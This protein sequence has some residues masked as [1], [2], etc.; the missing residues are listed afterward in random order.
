MP[1]PY[2]TVLRLPEDVDVVALAE[3]QVQEWL[4][5]RKVDG[6]HRKGFIS[7]EFFTPGEHELGR[8]RRLLVARAD[9][10]EDGSRR[11]LLRFTEQNDA[12]TW[13]VDAVAL[14]YTESGAP[15]RTLIVEAVRVDDPEAPGQV[16]PPGLVQQLLAEQRVIDGRTVVT[17][18]PILVDIDGIDEAFGAITDP[19]R[20]VEVIVAASA[21]RQWEGALRDRVASLTAK[22]TGAASVY[23]IAWGAVNELNAR[24]GR[25]HQVEFG[26]IR[27]FVP[28]V[29][30][31]D[32]A[33]SHR[34]R[35][36]GPHTFARA[37]KGTRV[38]LGLQQAFAAQA[39]TRQLGSPLPSDVRRQRRLL[40]QAV[41]ELRQA[42][43]LETHT[44]LLT[45]TASK[46]S[47]E[48][49]AGAGRQD[50][51]T[52]DLEAWFRN[53]LEAVLDAPLRDITK[54][55][56]DDATAAVK[57]LREYGEHWR[58]RERDQRDLL[59]R[60]QDSYAQL[61]HEYDYQGLE[62]VEAQEEI[63]RLSDHV[64]Y[65]QLQLTRAGKG[66]EAYSFHPD[67]TWATPSD[68]SELALL[69]M[70]DSS[71]HA[72][73]EK[74]VFTGNLDDVVAAQERDVNGLVVQR[75]WKAVRVLHDYAQAKA[76]GDFQGSVQSYLD[77]DGVSG[78]KVPST[79]HAPGETNATMERWG[80]E[81]IL[82]VP[83]S[84]EPS[85]R[86]TMKAHFKCDNSNTFAT[87]MY[88][89][90]DTERSGKVYVGYIG[91]HKTNTKTSSA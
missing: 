61:K 25:H 33:D 19:S 37:I 39:R 30:L 78:L 40:E 1:L 69:L 70:P 11:C 22:V 45:G 38:S 80:S 73:C 51:A 9:R 56:V 28:G 7:G 6:H 41:D 23:V 63:S 75:A 54:T 77:S 13:Q 65:L 44:T 58:T 89:F 85:G 18:Q 87:H 67:T 8:Q 20:N 43:G 10:D 16:D 3:R 50:G 64:R 68:L 81:R 15:R 57:R 59:E 24:L 79:W 27:T 86:V 62:L 83:E 35:I 31:G 46:T 74:V 82:P 12:G 71:D 72:V 49:T 60:E 84:V 5:R 32:A 76:T 21:G 91:R 36:L 4:E 14:Q 17:P 26:H 2:R 55:V 34:H 53:L 90:D 66:L 52:G 88:Y 42:P 29:Q 48:S 47:V